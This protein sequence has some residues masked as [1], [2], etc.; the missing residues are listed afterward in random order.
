MPTFDADGAHAAPPARLDANGGVLH[1]DAAGRRHV[2]LRG[3]AQEDV[4]CGLA[5]GD[6]LGRHG[7]L[8]HVVEPQ[9]V[10][11]HVD[12]VGRRRRGDR[13]TPATRMEPRQ[14]VADAGQQLYAVAAHQLAVALFLEGA[15]ALHVGGAD[16]RE[17]PA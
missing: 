9:H 4:G 12:V 3:G 6:F 15:D 10:D 2:D 5:V 1:D 7:R 8:E 16:T 14:P 17:S 13:L 11:E